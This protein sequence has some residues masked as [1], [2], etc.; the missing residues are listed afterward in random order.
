NLERRA[1][2]AGR[3]GVMR[4][5]GCSP[6]QCKPEDDSR[7]ESHVRATVRRLHRRGQRGGG[8]GTG[9]GGGPL[10]GRGREGAE[11]TPTRG[12]Q[13]SRVFLPC[14]RGPTMAWLDPRQ[15][16]RAVLGVLRGGPLGTRDLLA[17][18]LIDLLAARR[19]DLVAKCLLDA[20][21]LSLKIEQ[22]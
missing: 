21:I 9:R 14:E 6:G 22:G 15:F 18:D 13:P 11:S 16:R 8:A 19:L 7:G 10:G 12:G 17:R 5:G 1:A 2:R 3:P 4:P 20:E